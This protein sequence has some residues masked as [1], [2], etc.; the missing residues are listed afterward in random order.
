MTKPT[1]AELAAAI[2]KRFGD[3]AVGL[4]SDPDFAVHRWPTGIL[5]I[6]HVLDGG[7]P[8]GRM[9]ELFG[10]YSTMKSYVLYR[11]LAAVQAEGGRAALVD[12]EHAFDPIWA[13]F[14]GV[15][16]DT[17]LVSWPQDAEQGVGV[18][19][20][21]VRQGY[22]IVGFDSIAAALPRQY[23]ENAPGEDNQ[24]GALARVMSKGLARLN[25]ANHSTAMVFVNQTRQKIGMT[26]GS[27]V[28]TSGGLAM[29]FYA[30]YRLSFTRIEKITEPHERWN[31]DKYVTGKRVVA[32]RIQVTREKSKLSAPTVDTIFDYDLR[33]GLVDDVGY[34]IAQGL[35]RG[36]ITR[37][38]K[39][40]WDI[41]E[42]LPKPIHGK[43]RFR[44]T[45]ESIPEVVEWIREEV[46]DV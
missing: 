1:S 25:A 29:G 3:G 14:L 9:I 39:G 11:A 20:V 12:A 6:D 37:D 21:L 33:T 18:L 40:R 43:D 26:F 17:L 32:H 30:S 15:D 41:P 35:E 13:A 38:A 7:V 36:L 10:P 34:L 28:T 8:A 19:E 44:A 22:D 27:P 16:V 5:P 46:L 2:N 24:P 4:A 23:R 42:V 31:G 45:F